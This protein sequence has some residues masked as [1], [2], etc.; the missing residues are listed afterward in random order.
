LANTKGSIVGYII[1]KVIKY[2]QIIV[3]GNNGSLIL[4]DELMK[5]RR[6]RQG[7]GMTGGYVLV[8]SPIP[9][10]EVARSK[11]GSPPMP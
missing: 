5:V 3:V 2:L 11:S 1:A 8:A 7:L 10:S 9:Y 4:V 6:C